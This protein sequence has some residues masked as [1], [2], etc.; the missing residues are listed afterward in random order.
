MNSK[1]DLPSRCA[2]LVFWL[3]NRLSRQMTSCP[4]PTSRS[5]VCAPRNPAPPV[6]SMRLTLDMDPER[7]GSNPTRHHAP[8]AHLPS[9][10]LRLYSLR[11]CSLRPS[12][13]RL[14]LQ[15]PHRRPVL[16]TRHL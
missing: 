3:V 12:H 15:L 2:M 1:F 7:I 14:L 10:P 11:L 16:Q 9:R 8:S 5:Q 6:T 4:S 13:P